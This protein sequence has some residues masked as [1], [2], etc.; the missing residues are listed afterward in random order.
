MYSVSRRRRP[1]WFMLTSSIL[2]SLLLP[3]CSPST[4]EPS[5][6]GESRGEYD[7]LYIRELDSQGID[8]PQRDSLSAARET[9]ASLDNGDQPAWVAARIER[10]GLK[11]PEAQY[12]VFAAVKTYCD[13]HLSRLPR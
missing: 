1:A 8:I 5:R 4:I 10:F 6:I 9:C 3:A 13:Q 12:T 7:Y 2:L 11:P